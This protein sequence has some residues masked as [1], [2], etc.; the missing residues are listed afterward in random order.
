MDS[1]DF[2]VGNFLD[3][4]A[5]FRYDESPSTGWSILLGASAT[6]MQQ[7][8]FIVVGTIGEVVNNGKAETRAGLFVAGKGLHIPIPGTPIAITGLGG[9]FFLNP[10]PQDLQLVQS[11]CQ[12]GQDT[13]KIRAQDATWAVLLYGQASIVDPNIAQGQVL[14]T[15]SDAQFRIDGT[16]TVF[17]AMNIPGANV[18]G[19]IHLGFT[20]G[21]VG[22]EG[23]I[24]VKVDY[25]GVVTGGGGIGFS[26]YGA[27]QWAISG[28]L[29][30]NVFGEFQ[31]DGDTLFIG[32][33][34]FYAVADIQGG[35]DVLFVSVTNGIRA[36]I[37]YFQGSDWGAYVTVDV[38][39]SVLDGLV[40]A[41]GSL[42]GALVNTGQGLL[43]YAN[44][45]LQ[46]HTPVHDWTGTVW[47]QFQNG[48][49]SAGLG[50]D[51]DM[52]AAI[53]AAQ[54]QAQDMMG[55]SNA[56]AGAI[57]A[58]KATASDISI[59][60]GDLAAAYQKF[61][62]MSFWQL[63]GNGLYDEYDQYEVN[64]LAAQPAVA[65]YF[66]RYWA[67]LNQVGAPGDTLLIQGLATDSIPGILSRIQGG[68]PAVQQKL[69]AVQVQ[70]TPLVTSPAP[71]PRSSPITPPTGSAATGTLRSFT[72]NATV[73]KQNRDAATNGAAV[74]KA[75]E[76]QV[77]AQLQALEAGLVTAHA[78]TGAAG[79]ST[80]LSFV[81]QY[82]TV[83]RMAEEQF[84]LQADFTLRK[85]DWANTQLAWL[86][87]QVGVIHTAITGQTQTLLTGNVGQLNAL[88]RHRVVALT[89]IAPSFANDT[90]GWNSD[91]NTPNAGPR[92]KTWADS[93]GMALWY[94]LD[95]AGLATISHNADS[96]Y[97]AL[98]VTAGLRLRHHPPAPPAD[99]A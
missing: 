84:A 45:Q 21:N 76:Q 40:S 42:S 12:V 41:T 22:A 74:A 80:L 61:A 72:V 58:A 82:D 47:V 33:G 16:V 86:E 20:L 83:E 93:A 63:L 26:V 36:Q 64:A 99:V 70:I 19:D 24:D 49:A 51:P 97:R 91:W 37:W 68:L 44:A 56:V 23:L 9:G 95:S 1:A 48:S 38:S 89:T 71:P 3:M 30:L 62:Q 52:D 13:T 8:G 28:N 32:P 43:V 4:Q 81:Q 6:V 90:T 53:A 39:A 17:G 92:M 5:A 2:T 85:R 25:V 75:H 59:P 79:P 88:A 35:F 54:Q 67:M 73:A 66:Q 94:S 31:S 69:N 15:L 77:R 34:G 27:N 46:V 50:D 78:A 18:N 65:P 10:T 11:L 87:S 98:T 96:V 29:S 7:A 14:I 60:K 57:A 55:E